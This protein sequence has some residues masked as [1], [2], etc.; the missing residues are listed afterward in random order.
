MASSF[1][2]FTRLQLCGFNPLLHVGLNCASASREFQ[3]MVVVLSTGWPLKIDPILHMEVLVLMD[4]GQQKPETIFF[5]G[6]IAREI[7]VCLHSNSRI[8]E[9]H[10]WLINQFCLL[11]LY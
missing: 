5:T 10:N 2:M 6:E 7:S 9:F 3:Q 8:L 4:I 11:T 1:H